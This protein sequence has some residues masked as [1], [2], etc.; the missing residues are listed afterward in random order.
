MPKK[1]CT[2]SQPPRPAPKKPQGNRAQKPAA[3]G[4]SF[5]RSVLNAEGKGRLDEART[6]NGL[7]DEIAILRWR[8][9]YIV[10]K[11]VHHQKNPQLLKAMELLIRAYS[12]KMSGSKKSQD[13]DDTAV[14][15]ALRKAADTLGLDRVP[16]SGC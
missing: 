3:P 6:V 7:D 14:I 9:R 1:T 11:D 10:Q 15:D 8:I 13:A 16:W 5:Y 2:P 12:A 4:D